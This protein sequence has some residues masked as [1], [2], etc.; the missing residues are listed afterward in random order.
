MKK[1][2]TG[3]VVG[4]FLPYHKGH[5]NLIKEAYKNVDKLTVMVCHSDGYEI[6]PELRQK[7]IKDSFPEADVKIFRHKKYLDSES[8]DVSEE[9]A[10]IT[11]VFLGFTPEVLFS[12]ENYGAAYAKYMGSKHVMFDKNRITVPI[13][14]TKIRKDPFKHWEMLNDDVK[15]YYCKRVVVLGAEST[16]TTTLAKDLAKHYQ[17]AW[18]PEYGRTYYEGKM[19]SPNKDIWETGEF[20]HIAEQQNI[21]ED[22]LAKKSNKILICDTDSFTTSIWHYRYLGKKSKKV[23]NV[24]KG[25][26]YDLYIITDINT[27]FE[28]DGTRDGKHIREWMHK[29]FIKEL[30]KE[31]KDY[32]V[33]G[34][35]K[36]ARLKE[37][38]RKIET[39]IL[40]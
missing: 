13:S 15:A 11:K 18:V 25:R 21:M 10:Q 26:K 3:L 34:D 36:R 6:L 1:Y 22:N 23:E 4:K 35:S 31:N 28:Q 38:V 40:K 19:F 5:E 14:A 27:P 7:W 20:V 12:S 29:L 39:D 33:V 17:T 32:I 2:K 16:G 30:K 24:S 8:T 37:A 9:W